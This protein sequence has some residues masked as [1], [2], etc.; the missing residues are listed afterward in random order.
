MAETKLKLRKKLYGKKNM[1][2]DQVHDYI[3]EMPNEVVDRFMFSNPWQYD[4]DT[5]EKRGASTDAGDSLDYE[6]DDDKI[7][8]ALQ[9]EC[10]EKFRKSPQVDTAVRG[11]VGRLCGYG[12]GIWSDIYS[13]QSVIEEIEED[14]RNRLYHFMPKY[15]GRS[16]VEGELFLLFTCH[17]DGFI[18]IDFIDPSVISGSMDY[19]IIFHPDKSFMP[20][21]YNI[22][23][24]NGSGEQDHLIPSIYIAHYPYLVEEARKN[25]N[26]SEE[27]TQGS[28][29]SAEI[30]KEFGGYYR[31]V[32]SWN[33]GFLTRRSISY[34]R[35]TLQW[36]EHYENLKKYEIDHKKAAGA[37]LWT[38]CFEDRQAFK[39]W[40]SLSDT[41]KR[42]TGIMSK[43][44]PGG[45]LILPPGMSLDVKNPQ[46]PRI[47]D[48][49]KDI[50]QM[51]ISGLNEPAD[52]TTG[53]S[54]APF[55]S[56]KASRGPM[57]DRIS[58]EVEWLH[59]FLRFDFWGSVFFLR[60]KLGKMKRHF[61]V[62]EAVGW[63]DNQEPIIKKVKRKPEKL[64]EISS[65]VSEVD[66]I[67]SRARAF[68]GV[69]HGSLLDTLGIPGAE[70]AKRLGFSNYKKLRLR[71]ETEKATMSELISNIDA[72]MV[73]EKTESEPSPKKVQR[74]TLK[75][76]KKKEAD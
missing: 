76:R 42:E 44:T 26:F 9:K 38:F 14:P 32:V 58:D 13:I 55:A 74:P 19:G 23:Y 27:N 51:I 5:G 30:F 22:R 40:H 69:K 70:V 6:A 53:S 50:M 57:S 15:V 12:F 47:S 41:Q 72:E 25:D 11:L 35:T 4:A 24:D 21:F 73:Q 59:R 36:I 37:Y 61:I 39:L 75:K 63:D 65:P 48:E 10:W 8:E 34:L 71:R 7:R 56:V 54:T 17:E 18:E 20:L 52:V 28:K 2:E 60:H 43:I 29:S 33:R 67:E 62:D 45:R 1:T 68:L 16:L 46:L 49:D 3:M 64:I 31:F 66:E